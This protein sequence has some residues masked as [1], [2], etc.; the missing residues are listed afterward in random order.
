MSESLLSEYL[1]L[2]KEYDRILDLSQTLLSLLKQEDEEGIESVLEKKSNVA[3]NIQFLTEKLSNKNLSKEDQKDF[4][5]IK[6]ELE[7]IEEKAY[8]LLELEKKVGFLFQEKY[9]K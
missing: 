8:K 3:I 7:K 1:K 6:K 9:K 4:H 2:S 5:L